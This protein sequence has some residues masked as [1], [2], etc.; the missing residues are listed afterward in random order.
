MAK[1]RSDRSLQREETW[2]ENL[3]ALERTQNWGARDTPGIS[4]HSGIKT[5]SHKPNRRYLSQE[6]GLN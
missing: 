1:S 5:L 6:A 2:E 4:G 3:V